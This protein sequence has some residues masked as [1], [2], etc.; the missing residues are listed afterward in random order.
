MT[1]SDDQE[2][3]IKCSTVRTTE[4]LRLP[5]IVISQITGPNRFPRRMTWTMTG[6]I[7]TT[8]LTTSGF[9]DRLQIVKS[10]QLMNLSLRAV[11]QCRSGNSTTCTQVDSSR[12]NL[13]TPRCCDGRDRD[14]LA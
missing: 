7:N 4:S 14:H 11:G 3:D 12:I 9:L 5:N 6:N 1:Y 10:E 13:D 8:N 2:I